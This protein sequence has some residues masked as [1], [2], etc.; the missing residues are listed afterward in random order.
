MEDF[1]IEKMA[2]EYAEMLRARTRV[3]T[4][5][6]EVPSEKRDLFFKKCSTAIRATEYLLSCVKIPWK[7]RVLLELLKQ[8]KRIMPSC[9][10]TA[11]P[12]Y[13]SPDRALTSLLYAA[14]DMLDCTDSFSPPD[15]HLAA[16][17]R[18]LPLISFLFI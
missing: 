15:D 14:L 17:S 8:L 6:I 4:T 3:T 1:D 16:C 10:K 18:L 7:K 9:N 13:S 5:A 12:R 11:S 2:R